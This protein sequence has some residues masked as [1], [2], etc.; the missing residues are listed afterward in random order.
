MEFV[1]RYIYKPFYSII[2]E[3]LDLPVIAKKLIASFA[4]FFFIFMWHGTVWH[5]F[6][7]SLLNYSGITLEHFGKFISKHKIYIYF[8]KKIL[9]TDTMESRFIAVLCSPLLALSAISNFY[10]FAGSDVGNL[11]FECFYGPSLTNFL[12]LFISLYCCCHVS[13]ALEDFPSRGTKVQ[14]K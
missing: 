3:Y 2:Y 13:M 14:T 4:T 12:T 9:R 10:L 1:F 6:I 5:I 7:W 8:K 11:F